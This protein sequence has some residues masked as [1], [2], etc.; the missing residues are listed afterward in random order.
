MKLGHMRKHAEVNLEFLRE[1]AV[2]LGRVDTSETTAD[3]FTKIV[4]A[5]RLEWHMAK[6]TGAP[7]VRNEHG[8][9]VG[10]MHEEHSEKRSTAKSVHDEA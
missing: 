5:Q 9:I 10:N 8:S 1:C 7:R 2:P 6:F 4:S 3:I